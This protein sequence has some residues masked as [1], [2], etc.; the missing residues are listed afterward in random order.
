MFFRR[1][2]PKIPTFAERVDLLKQ[3]GFA[4]ANLPDGRVKVTK[5]GV[6]AIIG[7]EGKN[8]PAI[9]K[10]GLLIGD[11]I[12]TLLNAGYQMFIETPGGTRI[13][14]TAQQLKGLHAFEADVKNA[15][16]LVD[17]YNTSLGTTSRK[18]MYDRVYKR[19]IGE[20]PTPWIRKDN[21]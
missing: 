14:A 15:L 3:A 11:Q 1:E 4:A 19:D 16:G 2:R 20:Q 9:E 6:G 8:Q 12:A 10:A 18:H 21:R 13:P 7:D 17:L 5:H